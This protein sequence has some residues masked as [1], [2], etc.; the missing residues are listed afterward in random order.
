LASE[1]DIIRSY[2]EEMGLRVVSVLTGDGRVAEIRAAHLADLNLVQCSGSMRSLAESLKARYGTPYERVSYFGIEDT[3]EALYAAAK[4]FP[5]RPSVMEAAKRLVARELGRA[6]PE[7]KRLREGLEGRRAAIYVGGG[8]KALSLVKALRHLGIRTAIVGSQTGSK[9]D[10]AALS[11]LCDPGT[12]VVDDSNPAE[13]SRLIER[14][15]AELFIGGVKERPMAYKL[16]LAFC[17]HNH[18]RKIAL[19]GF[20]GMLN[21][22]REVRASLL[23]PV[24]KL[25]PR[26]ARGAA[27]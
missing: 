27:L 18:E 15:G 9:D 6:A 8:F 5:G 11:A 21:F 17:D 19:A 1:A 25:G 4:A 24:W 10:Y 16:G 22:A 7:L 20:E 26:K 23:S 12:V 14:E 13:L 2:Y 3:A